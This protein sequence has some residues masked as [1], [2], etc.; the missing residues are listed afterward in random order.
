MEFMRSPGRTLTVIDDF[1]GYIAMG[2]RALPWAICNNK[3]MCLLRESI[4]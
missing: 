3:M 4:G 2:N 1:I